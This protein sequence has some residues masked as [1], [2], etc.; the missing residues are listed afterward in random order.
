MLI[1]FQY[2]YI[3]TTTKLLIQVTYYDLKHILKNFTNKNILR[4]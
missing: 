1:K 3:L 4:Y 2:E